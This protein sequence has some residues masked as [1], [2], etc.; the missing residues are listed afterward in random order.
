[1]NKRKKLINILLQTICF[2]FM[3]CHTLNAQ[4][5][6]DLTLDKAV[7]ITMENSYNIKQLKLGI[8]ATRYRLKARQASLKSNVYMNISS[9]EIIAIANYKW[10]STLMK[11]EIVHQDTRR[12]Q[13][14]LSIRQPVILLG[15]PTNGYLSL[16]GRIYKYLQNKDSGQEVDYYNRYFLQFQQP[17]FQPNTLKNN[18]EQAELDLESGELNY[19]NNVVR[20]INGV[21][22]EYFNMFELSYKDVIYSNHIANLQKVSEIVNNTSQLNTARSIEEIQI[23]VELANTMEKLLQNQSD[24]RLATARMRQRLRLNDQDSLIV[25]PDINITPINVPVGQAVQYGYTLRPTLRLNDIQKRRNEIFLQQTSANGAVSI[26]LEMTYGLEKQDERYQKLLDK[27]KNSY[28]VSI[29]AYIPILDWGRRKSNIEAWKI[30]IK[31]TELS[32]EEN[33]KQIESEITNAV[34]NLEEYQKRALNMEENMDISKELCVTCMIQFDNTQMSLQEIIK[35]IENQK[36][37]ELN[38]LDAYLGYRRSLIRLMVNTHY[39][40]ENN[41]SFIDKFITQ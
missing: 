18:I 8:E 22:N 5:S 27:Q 37:T 38:F 32:I 11:D 9:P 23:Q 31:T 29:R 26:N 35:I 19:V 25:K 16:N 3:I 41:I 20:E 33:R 36:D 12:W 7:D 28:S 40:F 34:V 17:L 4:Q 39:D 13:M 21:A 24:I 6:I 14:D 30:S 10:N 1:M 15:Y 2:S